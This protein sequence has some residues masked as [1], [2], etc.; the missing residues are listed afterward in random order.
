VHR[1]EQQAHG[2]QA[3]RQHQRDGVARTDTVRAQQR[4]DRAAGARQLG[5][6]EAL[7]RFGRDGVDGVRPLR[8]LA[9]DQRAD[10]GRPADV[11]GRHAAP[12]F[13]K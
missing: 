13:S 8:C 2:L 12:Y 1:T 3:V 5:K 7:V 6:R 10:G 11:G 4:A 9:I